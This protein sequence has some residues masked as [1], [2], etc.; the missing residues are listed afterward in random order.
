MSQVQ[1]FHNGTIYTADPEGSWAEAVALLTPAMA[2]HERIGG[3]RAQRDLLEFMY[4][5]AL[6][7]LDRGDEAQR[8]LLMRRPMKADAHAV[9]G[10]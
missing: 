3:S 4:V 2:D 7:R 5:G 6:L 9:A 1:V 8:L 10:L